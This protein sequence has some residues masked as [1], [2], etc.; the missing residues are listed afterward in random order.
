MLNKINYGA[1]GMDAL[2]L[3]RI[4]FGVSIGFHY[5]F[6]AT[7]LGLSLGIVIYQALALYRNDKDYEACAALLIKI[8]APV[9]GVGVASGLVMPFAFGT[10]WPGFS[11]YCAEIFG[12]MLAIEAITAFSLESVFLGV[13]IFAK[14]RVSPGMYFVAGLCVFIGSHLSAFWI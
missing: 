8:L 5:L 14:K 11:R 13:L 3:S 12:S 1:R 6:P 10:N 4:Q 9:F 7:T 2:L